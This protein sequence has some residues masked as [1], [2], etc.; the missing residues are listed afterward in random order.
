MATPNSAAMTLATVQELDAVAKHG[1]TPLAAHPDQSGNSDESLGIRDRRGS[2]G[3][4]KSSEGDDSGDKIETAENADDDGAVVKTICRAVSGASGQGA[5]AEG[6]APDEG[7]ESNATKSSSGS[8]IFTHVHHSL[9]DYVDERYP[10]SS[11]SLS[12]SSS[13]SGRDSIRAG[14]ER[15]CY[16]NSHSFL[17]SPKLEAIHEVTEEMTAASISEAVQP[18]PLST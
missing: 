15:D 6:L 10:T 12:T 14:G 5:S 13:L 17:K 2:V 11:L 1:D 3:G 18:T 16:S 8:A 9:S 7:S 4:P